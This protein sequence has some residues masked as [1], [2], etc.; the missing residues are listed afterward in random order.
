MK[1]Y[2]TDRETLGKFID[3]L[4]KRKPL[5]V[6][7][8]EELN[9]LRE[10]NIKAIDNRIGMEVFGSLTKEQDAELN[11]LLDDENTP[12]EVFEDFFQKSGVDVEQKMI[13]AMED[14]TME[15]LGGKNE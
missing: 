4:F 12:P 3:E 5:P 8:P 6:D 13:K 15:F 14:F 1:N 2:L 7:S 10:E 9:T 11:R